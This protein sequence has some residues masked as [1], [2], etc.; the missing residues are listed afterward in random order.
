MSDLLRTFRQIE[1]NFY[2]DHAV[3]RAIRP[4]RRQTGI[5]A[6]IFSTHRNMEPLM[7]PLDR[8]ERD[9]I[10]TAAETDDLDFVDLVLICQDPIRYI[11]AQISKTVRQSDI[12]HAAARALVLT[13]ATGTQTI[14][15]A[16]GT[17]CDPDLR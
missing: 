4:I 9:S 3:R 12:D 7:K 2:K 17:H 6:T 5:D 1:N 16:V 13:K 15:F 10:I 14:P 8:A 11:L